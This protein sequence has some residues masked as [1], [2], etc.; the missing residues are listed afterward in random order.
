MKKILM[1]LLTL[2]AGYGIATAQQP[3]VVANDKTGW[4]KIGET[5]VDF[6]NDRDVVSVMGADRF[7]AIRF[8]VTDASLDLKDLEVYYESGDKQDIQVRT[9]ITKGAESRVIDLNGG[10]RSLQKIVFVYSTVPNQKEEK[11]HVEIWGL[12]TNADKPVAAT[13]ADQHPVDNKSMGDK[14]P[15]VVASDKTGW[16]KIAETHVDLKGDRDEIVVM[17]ADKFASIKF[18]VTDASIELRDLEVYYETGNKE[19]IQIRKVIERGG[20]SRVIDLNGGER[21]L[22]KVVFVYKTIPNQKEE[23]AHVE[24]WGLKTNVDKAVK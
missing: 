14:K 9:P 6:K 18:K 7:A 3:A 21:A 10:E 15:V 11:A 5:T 12:K 4:H 23:K 2:S 24:L 20:E 8:K 13:S 19:D 22:K 16:H 17:G 1:I